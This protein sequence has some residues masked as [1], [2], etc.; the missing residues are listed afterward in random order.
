MK[1]VLILVEGQ[2]EE[3]FVKDVL[4]PT[5]WP[6]AIDIIPKIVT[7]KRVKKGPDFKGGITEYRKVE[8]DLR[9]LLGDTAALFVT[10]FIDYYGLPS[11]FPGMSTRPSGSSLARARHVETEWERKIAHQCFH[12]YLMIHEF[13]A[14]L[15]ARPEELAKAV[16]QPDA[17]DKLMTIRTSFP[18]PEDIDDDPHNAPSKRI[19]RIVPAYQKTLHG[20]LITGRIG[21]E[22]LRQECPHFNEWLNWLESL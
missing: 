10:T 20:P 7:T 15:F 2:T 13:E 21:L 18:T 5:L 19:I 14:L 16:Y 1:R 6:K 17:N 22:V 8:N 3:R 4:R 11:D 9:R 12:A